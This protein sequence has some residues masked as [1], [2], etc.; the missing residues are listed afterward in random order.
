MTATGNVRINTVVPLAQRTTARPPLQT[1]PEGRRAFGEK[2][3]YDA[4]TGIVVLT[5]TPEK[6]PVVFFAKDRAEA[7]VVTYDRTKNLLTLDGKV[8]LTATIPAKEE[9]PVLPGK[10]T[11]APAAK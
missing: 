3:V 4:T 7:D 5:G 1:V 9:A 10:D 11:P 2:G 6:R 8:Q